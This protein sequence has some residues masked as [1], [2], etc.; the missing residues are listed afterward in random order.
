MYKIIYFSITGP[1]III[2]ENIVGGRCGSLP[3]KGDYYAD[4]GNWVSENWYIKRIKIRFREIFQ[5]GNRCTGAAADSSTVEKNSLEH[6]E[7]CG[8]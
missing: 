2:I 4:I 6:A 7:K 8:D 1:P 5:R 3:G